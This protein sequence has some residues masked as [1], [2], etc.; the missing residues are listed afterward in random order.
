MTRTGHARLVEQSP[1]H[2]R[3][4]AVFACDECGWLQIAEAIRTEASHHWDTSALDGYM[5]MPGLDLTWFPAVGVSQEFDDVPGHIADA[6][7]EAHRC[8]SIGAYRATASLARAVVEATAKEKGIKTGQ[9]FQ[10]IES[11]YELKHIREHI[12]DGAH[13]IRYLGN[14]V[15]HGDFVEPVDQEEAEEVMALMA[16]VLQEVF[17]SPARVAKAAARR[18]ERKQRGPDSTT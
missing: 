6:A 16:E 5:E 9:I 18:A 4:Q 7:S 17:Q 14:E 3:V 13:E 8:L 15:A 10:K 12:R 2:G 1:T 11:L